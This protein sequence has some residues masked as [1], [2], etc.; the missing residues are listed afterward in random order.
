MFFFIIGF[1]K[2]TVDLLGSAGRRR[3]PNCGNTAEW[4]TMRLRS[5]VTLFFI[6][7]FPCKTETVSA[8]PICG[9]RVEADRE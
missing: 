9:Y 8:C 2:R 7:V 1:G 5:W 6:P 4:S 3:C